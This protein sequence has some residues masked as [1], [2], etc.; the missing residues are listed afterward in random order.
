M[1]SL[2]QTIDLLNDALFHAKPVSEREK[3]HAVE[4]ILEHQLHS[5]PHAGLFAAQKA[6]SRTESH[7]FTGE[8]LHTQLGPRNVIS[9]E[10]GRAILLLGLPI[11]HVAEVLERLQQRLTDECF[12]T[13]YCQVGECAHSGIGFMRYLA[14][15]DGREVE[16]RLVQHINTIAHS[17]D[18]KGKWKH[19]P[20]HYTLLALSEIDLPAAIDEMRYAAPALE[21][22]MKRPGYVDA[23]FDQRRRELAERVL[24]IC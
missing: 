13:Q 3:Q 22:T 1:I 23:P 16:Q 18:D 7:L 2:A 21:K 9:C 12:A 14:V 8:R 4:V 19:I 17:R 20:F 11:P 6:D 15:Q 24:S 10:T 5:G